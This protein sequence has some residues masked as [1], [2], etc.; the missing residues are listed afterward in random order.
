M[1]MPNF[2]SYKYIMFVDASGD[3]G[4][5]FKK[6]SSEGSSYS[7]VVSCFVTEPQ[8]LEYNN[9]ILMEMKHSLFI[10]PE[11][12]IKSTALKRHRNADAA[13]TVM[14]RLKGFA[15]SLIADKKLISEVTPSPESEFRELSL[16]A[17]RDIS[18]IT[19][20]FP[21]LSL[22]SS[23]LVTEND[24]ILIVIDNMKKREMDSIKS[25]LSTDNF[26]KYDLIFR[27]SKDKDFS[28]IQIADIMAGTIRTYYE[29]CL[30]LSAHNYYCVSCFSSAKRGRRN[31]LL[32][33]C[34]DKKSHKLYT[35]YISDYKF[36]TVIKFHQHE[37]TRIELAEHLII[38][39]VEQLIYFTYIKCLIFK[40][41][42]I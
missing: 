31:N 32:A 3:D 21:Y 8:N 23:R 7:F 17:Q 14:S 16:I 19:H 11:Q 4:Y 36:N 30:P 27:D 37:D 10:K 33:K 40:T 9:Q 22:C 20:T 1:T 28:L 41:G 26:N 13:Y 38:L 29:S 25:I 34:T 2:N 42:L 35:K 18:G 5:K 12:E 6:T 24:K 15:Y 39:P